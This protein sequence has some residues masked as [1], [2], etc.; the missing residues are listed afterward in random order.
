M[1][2]FQVKKTSLG[3]V[4]M[5]KCHFYSPRQLSK[6]TP[7]L[8]YLFEFSTA[9]TFFDHLVSNYNKNDIWLWLFYILTDFKPASY[10][11]KEG[12]E[13]TQPYYMAHRG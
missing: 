4:Q 5:K 7:I 12:E 1:T 11:T 10:I 13:G 3:S 6:I 8:Q 2:V 9:M